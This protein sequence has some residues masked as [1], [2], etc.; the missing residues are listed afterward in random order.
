MR[1]SL[2]SVGTV[3]KLTV[4]CTFKFTA[5]VTMMCLFMGAFFISNAQR[6]Q[7][8]TIAEQL[9]TTSPSPTCT[10]GPCTP[11]GTIVVDGNP[12]DWSFTNL[13][14]FAVHSYMQDAFGNGVVDSQFTEG[15]KDFFDAHDLRWSVSQTKAKNDIANGAAVLIGTTLYFA[16]D[17]TSN[18]GDAQIGF[19][20]YQNGTG[21]VIEADGT[22]DFA[23]DHAVGDLLVLADFTG[24]GRDA[25]VTVYEWVGTGGNV[26][27]TG[28]TLNTTTCTGIV[29][30]NNDAIYPVPTGWNFISPCYDMN[31]FYE[32][33]IN[34]ACLSGGGP[35]NLCFS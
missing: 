18:N 1:K 9:V 12:C 30:Q 23:P 5:I 34:L 8:K 26:P 10:A 2:P 22:H 3:K 24:G 6:V 4:S 19:W 16:G 13:N 15:S 25:N 35:P 14:T 32:G 33:Q 29:A 20:F 7:Q 31:E 17:R 11:A 27:N 21:P 28:G